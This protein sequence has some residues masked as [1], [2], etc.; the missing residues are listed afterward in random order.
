MSIIASSLSIVF[1]V[2]TAVY[3]YR[4]F[5]PQ[6]V[7]LVSGVLMLSVA[8]L[9]GVNTFELS[10]PTNNTLF[11]LFRLMEETF[12]TNHLRVGLMIMTIGGYVAFMNRIEATS[13]LVYVSMKPLGFFHKYPYWAATLVI[14]IG[15]LLFITTPSA[16][17]LGLLLVASVYPV[18]VN[19][20]VSRLT[21]LSVISA[22]TI[23]DQ[24][25]GS[26]NTALASELIGQTNVFYFVTHQIPLVIPTTLVVMAAYYFSNRYFDR[27]D[28]AKN[29]EPQDI[30][31]LKPPNVNVPL[32]FAFLP[33]LP[34]FLLIIFSPY[35]NLFDPPIQINTTVAMFVSLFVSIIF[36][37]FHY[38]SM[39]RTF[40]AIS[41]FWK[42]MGN[43][44][45]TVV[46]LIIAAEVFSKGLISLG[47]I[48]SLVSIT[49][50]LGMSGIGVSAV[51]TLIVFGA[52]MLM[53]SGNAAFFSFG[54]LLP[55]IAGQL[56]LPAHVM[57]LPMQLSSSMGRAASPIAGVIVAIAGV[58]GVSSAD[59]AKR[60]LLPL[61]A[62]LIFM[63]ACHFLTI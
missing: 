56:S 20:G 19:L 45:A 57:V 2:I 10:K 37:L 54:P 49:S 61:S 17:G 32:I 47:F 25:P 5:N 6:A 46:T 7:L 1:I 27:K 53:G 18:L 34:L 8:V 30:P 22:A 33:V 36:V 39:K 58:A 31:E 42:G 55:G 11:D 52:A 29:V 43:V 28:R 40:E 62:G 38:R 59:I 50:H 26:A 3:L 9:L 4:K 15:Q 21:A 12:Q 35:L 63:L 13:A 51:I 44:F 14:P 48:D 60:N 16:V 23:F 41:H 24:G